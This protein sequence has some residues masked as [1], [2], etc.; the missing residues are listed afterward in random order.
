MNFKCFYWHY[1]PE[2]PV[3]SE[4]NAKRDGKRDMNG[5]GLGWEEKG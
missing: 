4:W 2:P 1:I 5:S 3:K